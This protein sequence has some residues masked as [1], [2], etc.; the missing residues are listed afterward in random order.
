M[1]RWLKFS[2]PEASYYLTQRQCPLT[3]SIVF[4]DLLICYHFCFDCWSSTND[5]FAWIKNNC[6]WLLIQRRQK[7]CPT[8]WCLKFEWMETKGKLVASTSHNFISLLNLCPRKSCLWGW[9]LNCGISWM[10][11]EWVIKLLGV[12]SELMRSQN[13]AEQ[14]RFALPSLAIHWNKIVQSIFIWRQ[15]C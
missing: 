5:L 2:E 9:W 14:M 6:I 12:M 15:N 4:A 11:S 10:H 7:R 1:Q 3:D 8:E 13:C